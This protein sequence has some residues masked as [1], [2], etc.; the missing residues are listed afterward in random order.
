MTKFEVISTADGSDRLT[1]T[2]HATKAD[3]LAT[4]NRIIASPS[5]RTAR[6]NRLHDDGGLPARSPLGSYVRDDVGW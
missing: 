5:I 3:A 6:V 4:F 2:E 1:K